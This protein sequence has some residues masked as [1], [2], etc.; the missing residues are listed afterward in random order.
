MFV[1]GSATTAPSAGLNVGAGAGAGT[2]NVALAARPRKAT[3][4]RQRVAKTRRDVRR[5]TRHDGAIGRAERR[6]GR[7]RVDRER[8]TRRLAPDTVGI[9]VAV[10]DGHVHRPVQKGGSRIDRDGGAGLV[11]RRGERQRR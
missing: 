11:Y 3:A 2:V 6:R 10:A 9:V 8:D 7:R 4:P 1:V 5:R